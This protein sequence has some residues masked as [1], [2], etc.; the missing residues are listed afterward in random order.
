MNE[1]KI[2]DQ[3]TE[4][5]DTTEL[6]KNLKEIDPQATIINACQ[7]FCAIGRTKEFCIVNGVP[8]IADTEEEVIKKVK[9]LVE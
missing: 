7:G 4:E 8:V 6:E 3:C 9:E 5:K 1:F 2:C